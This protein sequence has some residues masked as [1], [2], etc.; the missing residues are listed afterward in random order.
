M[1]DRRLTFADPD[2]DAQAVR[3]IACHE[4][5]RRYDTAGIRAGAI[6]RLINAALRMTSEFELLLDW[7]DKNGSTGQLRWLIVKLDTECR[8]VLEANSEL[9]ERGAVVRAPDKPKANG[10]GRK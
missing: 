1:S 6:Q 4:A 3:M 2:L 7:S 8:K 5:L 10:K 9:Q